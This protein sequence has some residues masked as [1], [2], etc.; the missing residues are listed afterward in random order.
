MARTPPPTP[1]LTAQ[2]MGG[3]FTLPAGSGLPVSALRSF[4]IALRWTGT[5]VGDF[6][7]QVSH[8]GTNWQNRGSTVAAGGA[9]GDHLFEETEAFFNWARIDYAF[10]SSTG[11]ADAT[12]VGVEK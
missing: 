6:Q 8:D 10:G 5:P 3:N 9:A 2:S 12:L 1:V 7:L 11:T 4:S